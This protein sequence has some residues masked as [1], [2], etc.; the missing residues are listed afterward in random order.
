MQSKQ[1]SRHGRVGAMKSAIERKRKLF[2][3]RLID[4]ALK[5]LGS[6]RMMGVVLCLWDSKGEAPCRRDQQRCPCDTH[7]SDEYS[8]DSR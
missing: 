4:I 3:D 7:K 2:D 1:R 8:R 6:V 5:R